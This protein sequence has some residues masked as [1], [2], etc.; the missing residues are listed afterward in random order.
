MV[1]IFSSAVVFGGD[2]VYCGDV[3]KQPDPP[4][5]AVHANILRLRKEKGLTQGELGLLVGADN[6][7]VSHWERGESAPA[8]RRLPMVAAALGVSVDELLA[9]YPPRTPKT[10]RARRAS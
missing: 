6:T 4:D 3:K 9:E 5:R 1:E 8:M 7:M 10:A 2:Y